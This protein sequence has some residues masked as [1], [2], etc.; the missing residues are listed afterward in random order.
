MSQLEENTSKYEKTNGVDIEEE[1]TG[2]EIIQQCREYP[3]PQI[4]TYLVPNI[5]DISG[6]SVSDSH[7]PKVLFPLCKKF[8]ITKNYNYVMRFGYRLKIV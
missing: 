3:V 1:T 5:S 6:F 4:T 7:I 2:A 8:Q